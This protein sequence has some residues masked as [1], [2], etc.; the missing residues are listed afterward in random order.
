MPDIEIRSELIALPKW[1]IPWRRERPHCAVAGVTILELAPHPAFKIKQ[2]KIFGKRAFDSRYH[3][4]RRPRFVARAED[5]LVLGNICAPFK[6]MGDNSFL[7]MADG[8]DME[9][10]VGLDYAEIFPIKTGAVHSCFYKLTPTLRLPRGILGG[11]RYTNNYF[12]FLSEGLTKIELCCDQSG[13]EDIPIIFG[14][15]SKQQLDLLSLLWPD[16]DVLCLNA[17]EVIRVDELYMPRPAFY[18]P[19]VG[20]LW[21]T[22][23][24]VQLLARLRERL[25]LRLQAYWINAQRTLFLSR[26]SLSVGQISRQMINEGD[27]Q[28]E[29][30][31]RGGEIL[32]PQHLPLADQISMFAQSKSIITPAGAALANIMFCKP[33][34][35]VIVLCQDRG[36]HPD[37][38]CMLADVCGVKLSYV[39]GVPVNVGGSEKVHS[40]F[41]IDLD[42]FRSALKEAG[43]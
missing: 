30:L 3:R 41:R 25:R 29:V 20:D 10:S 19:L 17:G 7:Y 11:N 16:R 36:V 32:H 39:T 14:D 28:Q 8:T 43:V 38:F 13:M 22:T 26:G 34:T 35:E 1:R 9:L 23:Y 24:D 37:Y 27:L 40:S 4:R 15:I 21:N 6:Q 5:A 42:L 12:H 2:P 18:S 31:S 33:G